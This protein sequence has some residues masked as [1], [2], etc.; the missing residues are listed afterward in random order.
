MRVQGMFVGRWE[1]WT[2]QRR[3]Q[4]GQAL[5]EFSLFFV[6]MM[7]LIA[8]LVDIG[9]LLSDHI[10]VEYAARSGARTASVLSNKSANAD[11]A[12]I[13]AI[14]T[15]MTSLPN[16]RLTQITIFNAD[17]PTNQQTVYQAPVT[18]NGATLSRAP[19]PDNYPPPDRVNTL[20]TEHSIGVKLDYIYTFQFP[21]LFNG[22]FTSSD[23]VIMPA[24]PVTVPTPG[25]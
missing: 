2:R 6:L 5:V 22:T 23:Q 21:L 7:F 10:S 25:P 19:S 4:R 11:C 1:A 15:A 12:I 8:G 14:D 24:N 17:D 3:G 9:G 16:V 13:G 18:C 20:F